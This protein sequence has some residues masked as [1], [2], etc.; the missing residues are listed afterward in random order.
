MTGRHIGETS[1]VIHGEGYL[2]RITG[3]SVNLEDI[4]SMME[5]FH[6]YIM[7]CSVHQRDVKSTLVRQTQLAQS[8]VFSTP[9]VF[10]FNVGIW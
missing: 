2:Q 8:R 1:A 3:F 10:M 4:T 9:E 7:K 5:K 6:E